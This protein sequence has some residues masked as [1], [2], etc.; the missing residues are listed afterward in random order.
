MEKD[1]KLLSLSKIQMVRL[2]L[3]RWRDYF[4]D[5][6]S[7]VDATPIQ[8]YE[9]QVGED[10]EITETDVNAVIKSLRTGKAPGDDIRP[11][12]LK[13]MNMYGVR[14]LTRVCNG[15]CRTEQAPK[16][17]QI[18]MI[19]PIHKKGDKRKRTNDYRGISLISVPGK[20]YA[21]CL[22]KKCREIVESKLTDA[23]CGFRPGQSTM[24]Q[25]FVL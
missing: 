4:G 17:W 8:I 3:N 6:L 12:M 21:K 7:P 5:F 14:W 16:Q 9:E 19:I 2:C 24:D 10:I 22:K 15:A 1:L 23:Q 25:I 20:V 18:S 13:A 11:E